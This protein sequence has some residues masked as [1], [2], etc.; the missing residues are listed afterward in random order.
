ML[1]IFVAI[2]LAGSLQA[3]TQIPAPHSQPVAKSVAK[4]ETVRPDGFDCK[5]WRETKDQFDAC[6]MDGTDPVK[7]KKPKPRDDRDTA[8]SKRATD[9]VNAYYGSLNKHTPFGSYDACL[10][11]SMQSG[12][13]DENYIADN[14]TVPARIINACA[15]VMHGAEW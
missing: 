2:V 14:G 5:S 7:K 1:Y 4:S 8:T 15:V 11:L 6:M 13:R 9:I 3:A 12:S 10:D